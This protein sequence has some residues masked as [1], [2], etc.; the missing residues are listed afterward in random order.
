MFRQ[1]T[2]NYSALGMAVLSSPV[3]LMPMIGRPPEAGML[4]L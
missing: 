3:R 1:L 4:I 2:D